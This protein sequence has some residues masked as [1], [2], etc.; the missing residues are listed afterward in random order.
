MF[1]A[2]IILASCSSPL[3]KK[4]SSATFETDA[5]ELV[6]SK[7]LGEEDLKLLAAY[8]VFSKMRGVELEGKTYAEILSDAKKL[9]AENE[10]KQK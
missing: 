10:A 8:M 1:A 2:T 9:K 5:K 7:K 3:D 4:Y 6:E